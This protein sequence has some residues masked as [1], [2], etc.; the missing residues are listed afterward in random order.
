MEYNIKIKNLKISDIQ[1]VDLVLEN[2]EGCKFYHNEILDIRLV[3]EPELIIGGRGIERKI[4]SGYIEI[5][6]DE[7]T[8]RYEGDI[9]I[10]REGGNPIKKPYKGKIEK[11]LIGLC[12]ICLLILTYKENYWQE[13]IDVPYY[14]AT[15]D[16]IVELTVCSSAKIDNDGN[17]L[18]L[19]GEAS[20]YKS[21]N[22]P[23][24]KIAK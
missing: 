1:A 9:D 7:K 13:T 23:R 4:K 5:A 6:V 3:F 21:R 17:L 22:F 12:D 16:G 14:E 11:R 10:W 2:C 20:E 24:D 19:M 18:I 8:K 15:N